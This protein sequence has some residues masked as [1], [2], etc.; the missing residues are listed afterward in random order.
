VEN[1][2]TKKR[3]NQPERKLGNGKSF[4]TE[5]LNMCEGVSAIEFLELLHDNALLYFLVMAGRSN[6]SQ[7]F[8]MIMQF[9]SA[10]YR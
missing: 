7:L 1:S 3:F 8:R 2:C 6:C 4:S 5:L 10:D 9:Q